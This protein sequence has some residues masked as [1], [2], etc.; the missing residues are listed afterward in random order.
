MFYAIQN[1]LP[2]SLEFHV[3]NF[4]SFLLVMTIWLVFGKAQLSGALRHVSRVLSALLISLYVSLTAPVL[5]KFWD[6]TAHL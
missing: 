1:K 6:P 4:Y 2:V 5:D 3:I